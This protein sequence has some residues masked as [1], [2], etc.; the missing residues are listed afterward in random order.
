MSIAEIILLGTGLSMDAATVTMANMM[1]Y[2]S[3]CGRRKWLMPLFFGLFQG[4]MPFLGSLLG[5][6]I[7][8]FI[9]KYASVVMFLIFGALGVKMLWD[10]F[11]CAAQEGECCRNFGIGL[12]FVQAL[13]TS[14]DAFAVGVGLAASRDANLLNFAVICATTFAICAASL[15]LGDQ[16]AKL[17][18]NK[19]T[20][21][22]GA[23][24]I[25][26]AVASLF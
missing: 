15:L 26:I 22:G 11:R 25:V 12:V 17:L 16:F 9:S 10:G 3:R 4:L 1:A 18:R 13:A 24:L 6:L 2:G 23:I 20:L 21:C 7:A 19:A 14:I 8:G 5:S